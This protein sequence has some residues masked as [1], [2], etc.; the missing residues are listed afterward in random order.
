MKTTSAEK[1]NKV[2]SIL[3]RPAVWIS[4]ALFCALLWGS[5]FPAIKTGY[6]LFQIDTTSVYAILVFAG[7]RFTIAGLLTL[8]IAI[9]LTKSFPKVEKSERKGVFL[10]GLVQTTLQYTFFYIGL[11]ITTGVNGSILSSTSGFIAVIFAAMYYANDRLTAG[12]IIGI[13]M[14][15]A[16]VILL[17]LG[18]GELS[19]NFSF[20]GEGFML[21]S[22]ALS[23]LG[24][25]MS[26]ELTGK[27]G[28]FAVS[29]YQLLLGGILLAVVGYIGGGRL[30]PT[31]TAAYLLMTYLAFLSCSAFGIW[32]LLLK[33]HALSK[34]SMFKVTIP[35]FGSLLS[36]VFLGEPLRLTAVFSLILIVGGIVVLNRWKT[37]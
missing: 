1:P 21:I 10:L 37:T 6:E 26:K 18:E 23:A 11:S 19:T 24:A 7:V 2:A 34:I 25:L 31:G 17:N 13:L 36:I 35:I 14:G 3:K 32:T 9:P 22:A 12:K 15:L 5:A 29:G 4:A 8:L 16:G 20:F 27:T 30:A 33:Y 28:P